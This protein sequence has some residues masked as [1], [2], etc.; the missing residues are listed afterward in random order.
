MFFLSKT[1]FYNILYFCYNSLTYFIPCL[2]EL[3]SQLFILGILEEKNSEH[4]HVGG[5]VQCIFD[6]CRV[7]IEKFGFLVTKIL[8][9]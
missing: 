6:G 8:V 2:L 5:V 7:F 3:E 9:L 4:V 1:L